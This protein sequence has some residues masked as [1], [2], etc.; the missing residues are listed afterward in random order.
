MAELLERP[1]LLVP[2]RTSLASAVREEHKLLIPPFCNLQFNF[3]F[4]FRKKNL[5]PNYKT[6]ILIAEHLFQAVITLKETKGE[7]KT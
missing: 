4:V 7:G 6:N 3:S 1:V 2:T 5:I